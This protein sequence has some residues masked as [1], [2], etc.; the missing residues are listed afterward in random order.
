MVCSSSRVW[1]S[2]NTGTKACANAPSAKRRRKKLGILLAKKNT[3]ADA[4]AP[5]MLAITTSRTKPSTREINVITLTISPDLINFLL[6]Q[7]TSM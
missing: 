2:L 7:V 3:S 4:P 5:I 6:K 1:Y